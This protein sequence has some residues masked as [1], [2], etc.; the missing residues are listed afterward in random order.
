MFYV[1]YALR[2]DLF[3]YP[4]F[5]F[6]YLSLCNLLERLNRLVIIIIIIIIYS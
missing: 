4:L 2:Q 5:R 1:F 6:P 3:T